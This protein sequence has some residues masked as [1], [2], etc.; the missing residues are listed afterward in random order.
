MEAFVSEEPYTISKFMDLLI[1]SLVL[2]EIREINVIGEGYESSRDRRGLHAM[3]A[4][5]EGAVEKE[6]GRSDEDP[7]F[8]FLV[9]TC[10][11]LAPGL[12]GSFSGLRREMVQK[13]ITLVNLEHGVYTFDVS[14]PHAEWLLQAG[15]ANL[16][17]YAENLATVFVAGREKA[18]A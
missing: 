4:I 8:R 7:W 2:K 14:R 10:N 13:T 3:Y 6:R 1:A 15:H 12:D 17:L 16:V 18:V 9:R 5:A 11:E